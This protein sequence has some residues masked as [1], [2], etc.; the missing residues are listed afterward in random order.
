LI[1]A[2]VSGGGVELRGSALDLL[3]IKSRIAPLLPDVPLVISGAGSLSIPMDYLP[4]WFEVLEG[5][6]IDGSLRSEIEQLYEHEAAV[7]AGNTLLSGGTRSPLGA[8][9][10]RLDDYQA[11]AVNILTLPGLRGACL[12]DEQGT[13]KTVMAIASFD[14]LRHRG[15]IERMIVIC[16]LAM[17]EVWRDECVRFLGQG[18][19]VATVLGAQD[20]KPDVGPEGSDAFICNFDGLARFGVR[21]AALGVNRRLLLIVDESHA[22][23]SDATARTELVHQL[24]RKCE[25]AYVLCGTPAPN[26]F[27]D[28]PSQFDVADLGYTFGGWR[29]R[30]SDD[31]RARIARRGLMIRRLKSQVLPD[32][33]DKTITPVRVKLLPGQRWLYDRVAKQDV[34]ETRALD[35]TRITRSIVAPFRRRTLQLQICSWPEDVDPVCRDNAKLLVLDRMLAESIGVNRKKVV[36]WSFFSSPLRAMLSRYRTYSPVL[37]SGEVEASSRREVVRRFQEDADVRLFLGNPAAAGAGI[38]LTAA[39]TA[40]YFS[41]SNRAADFMQSIDRIH[42]R[43]QFAAHVEIRVLIAEDSVE[44]EEW[45]RLNGRASEQGDILGDSLDSRLRGTGDCASNES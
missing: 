9:D 22:V 45:T 4:A 13:G 24:R 38:T 43:G 35:G 14:L 34:L 17:V 8:W 32:L 19:N 12:F 20:G 5:C 7:R 15:C 26:G 30:S 40:I 11:I 28:L 27:V 33:P 41:L 23:K 29:P 6:Q 39:S 18:V 36:V 21:I 44:E 42:R 16:P 31:V 3:K 2:R 10:T 1:E 25:R 37:L